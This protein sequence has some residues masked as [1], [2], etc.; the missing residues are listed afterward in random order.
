MAWKCRHE[1]VVH[2]TKYNT[3]I[4]QIRGN[5]TPDRN[6]SGTNTIRSDLG[7]DSHFVVV[8]LFPTTRYAHT[9]TSKIN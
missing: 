2:P 1:I 9:V 3:K 7:L 4:E 6:M 5:V 8:I